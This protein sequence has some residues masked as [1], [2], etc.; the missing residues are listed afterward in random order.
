[1]LCKKFTSKKLSMDQK[2]N[3]AKNYLDILN[4]MVAV[5]R[6]DGSG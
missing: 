1:M 5:Q 2:L 4:N 6:L 3:L